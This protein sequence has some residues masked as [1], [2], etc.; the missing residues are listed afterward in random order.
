MNFWYFEDAEACCVITEQGVRLSYTDM[1]RLINQSAAWLKRYDVK[2]VGFLFGSNQVEALAIYL[3]ALRTGHAVFLY[4]AAA[5]LPFAEQL[6]ELYRPDWIA[7]PTVYLDQ[8]KG[9]MDEVCHLTEYSLSGR[10]IVREHP[11]YH[12]LAVLLTTSGTTGSP[13]LVR[14]SYDNLQT[15][16]SSIS[17][18]LNLNDS[19]RA[20]TTLPFFYSY[21]LSVVNSHL[22][23]R[24]SLILNNHS[25]VTRDFWELFKQQEATS[26]AGVPYTYQMLKRMKFAQMDLPSMRYMTQAGGRLDPSLVADF[27]NA[28]AGKGWRFYVMYGQTEAT[29]RISYIPSELIQSKM[30]SIGKAIPDGE[31]DLDPETQELIYKGPNVMLG[32][33]QSE[34]DLFQGDL[35]N[36]VLRTGDI[37][38]KDVDAFFYVKGRLKR[39]AKIFG[40]RVNLD[41]L[42]QHLEQEIGSELSCIEE[43]ERLVLYY[44]TAESA[45]AIRERMSSVFHIHHSGYRL[46]LIDELPRTASGK[47]DYRRLQE[48]E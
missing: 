38:S 24:A 14:L 25:V 4:D 34:E 40:L 21:G 7:G 28:A 19:E 1:N 10:T 11:V 16:A 8:I 45:E 30:G 41:E 15:N 13:K 22:N 46:E 39:F 2:T 36:G 31:L 6:I 27:A 37:A 33:A 17:Q 42:E 20:I 44:T 3:A 5:N 18:Y 9:A 32:Y 12:D 47:K 29:A 43:G 35:L 23:V 26:F 48:R